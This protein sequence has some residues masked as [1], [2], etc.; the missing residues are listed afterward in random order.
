MA[1]AGVAHAA[2]LAVVHQAWVGVAVD[3]AVVVEVAAEAAL[4]EEAEVAV[5][6]DGG[7]RLTKGIDNE[8]EN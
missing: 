6:V 3:S 5:V 7:S 1:S 4:V 2:A 8:I